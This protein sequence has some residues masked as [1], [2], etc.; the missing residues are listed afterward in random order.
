M[1]T[2]S[3]GQMIESSD[4]W[5]IVRD[6]RG[7][8]HAAVMPII[9]NMMKNIKKMIPDEFNYKL[10][11][12]S[13]L[14]P[15]LG[16][17]ADYYD[18]II[19]EMVLNDVE[20]KKPLKILYPK[21][22]DGN[23]FVMNGS[24]YVPTLFLERR[25]VDI[26]SGKKAID[27]KILINLLPT[28]HLRIMFGKNEI[29]LRNKT[30]GLNMFLYILFY[31]DEDNKNGDQE[32]KD[33]YQ[34]LVQE[35]IIEHVDVTKKQANEHIL[36]FLGFHEEGFYKGLKL[37]EFFDKYILL[38]HFKGMF[39][40]MF[41]T[42]N[43][44]DLIKHIV[45]LHQ[46]DVTFDMSDINNRRIVM[47]EYMMNPI[48]ELYLRLLYNVMDKKEKQAVIPTVNHRVVLTSGFGALM[49]RGQYYNISNPYT[50]PMI[51]KI[52]QDIYIINEGRIPKS[53]SANHAS[54]FGKICPVS[55]S[56]QKMGTNLVFTNSV[57]INKFGVIE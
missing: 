17:F 19:I 36:K 46:E 53:W 37:S 22:I 38:D 7:V 18:N 43:F 55:V 26:V 23:Y 1:N 54:G 52:S 13:A 48:Y 32:S 21:L 10:S 12:E 20:A 27:K 28:Y 2:L 3:F 29:S 11:K 5:K 47:T 42:D 49:H 30:M 14:S 33:Y 25:P 16:N 41:D 57:R 6:F 34:Y 4:D 31:L 51:N 8:D 50:V 56:A 24:M 45:K 35:N 39:K 44:K 9:E 15:Y 40:Y